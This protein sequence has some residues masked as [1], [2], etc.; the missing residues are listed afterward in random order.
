MTSNPIKVYLVGG[1]VRDTLLG[2]PVTEHDYVVVGATPQQLLDLGFSQVGADFPVFLHPHTHD[3]YA[4]A[5]TERKSGNGYLGFTVHADPTVTLEEDLIRRDLTINAMAIEVA[6]LFESDFKHGKFDKADVIDPYGGLQDI[7]NKQLRHVSQAFAE[8]PVRVLRLARF[9]SRY[10]PLGFEIAQDTKTLVRQMRDD[11]ELN[12]LV[13][14]RVWAETRKALSQAWAD[15]YFDSLENLSVLNVIMPNLAKTFEDDKANFEQTFWQRTAISMRLAHQ[16]NL[17]ETTRF[18]LFATVFLADNHIN[19]LSQFCQNQKIPKALQQFSEFFIQEF[20]TLTKFNT[21]NSEQ[22][23]DLIKRANLL[24]DKEK[25]V[26][27]LLCLHLYQMACEQITLDKIIKTLQPISAKDVD[28]EL[29]G[30]AIGEAIDTLRLTA[31][32]DL[33]KMNWIKK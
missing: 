6:G 7:E 33:V 18:A 5:R 1:A 9:A 22:L 30:K 10:A 31:L 11:G 20:D 29:S 3:E 16:F 4:L 28:K 24:K 2:R 19:N 21:L 27:A 26:Q 14:E 25:I 23:F 12:H 8:D 15:V 13:A 32:H 17:D